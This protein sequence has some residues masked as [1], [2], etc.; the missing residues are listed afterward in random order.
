MTSGESR[1]HVVFSRSARGSL[2]QAF[3]MAGRPDIAV[4]P[5]D[6]FS[7][8]P[9]ASA[10]AETRDQWVEEALGYPGW[11]EVF[12]DSLPVLAA[13]A[14][15][16]APPIV[17]ISPDSTQS[18][19][20]FLWWLSHQG[21]RDCLVVDVRHL[22]GL[23]AGELRGYLDKA[24]PL[25]AARRAQCLA[26]WARLRAEDAPLRV[27]G[28]QGL[29]SAPLDHFDATLLNHATPEW[30][31]MAS[32]VGTVLREFHDAGVHQV[33]DLVL[34]ARLADLAEAGVLEWR[35]ELDHM[36]GC[37]VRQPVAGR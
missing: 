30:R 10:D 2:E 15:A 22:H 17:W 36:T 14:E 16:S 11:G 29:V 5:H 21:D 13:S 12:Q 34:G 18:V 8:G 4:A 20:G 27:L 9:I 3:A 37:E 23:H 28:A 25:P 7:F 35:G 19:A 24:Q 31:T 32:I 33:G 6:D 1:L 26:A